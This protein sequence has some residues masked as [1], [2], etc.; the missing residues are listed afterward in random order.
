M[1][2]P[3]KKR[4]LLLTNSEHGQANVFLAVSY[5]LLQNVPPPELHVASFEYLK[6]LALECSQQALKNAASAGTK[7]ILFHTLPEPSIQNAMARNTDVDM[8]AFRRPPGIANTTRALKNFIGLTCPWGHNEFIS[9]FKS[10]V[11]IIQKV[12][13]DLVVVDNLLS[14]AMTALRHLEKR[15]VVLSPNTIKD[16][17]LGFADA[18]FK[19]P[20]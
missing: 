1:A 10:I 9:L 15:H 6:P 5:A 20:W 16:W 17:A 13:P 11:D 8:A 12:D 19:F 4:L 7:G 14:P 3:R 2:A 18:L